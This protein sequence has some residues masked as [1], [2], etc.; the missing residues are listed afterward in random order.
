MTRDVQAALHW[1]LKSEGSTRPLALMRIFLVANLWARWGDERVLFRDLN[2]EPMLASTIFF[3]STTAAFF[4]MF[5]RVS[6]AVVALVINY[7]VYVVGHVYGHEPYTHH[8]TTLLANA[9]FLLALAPCGRSLS[10]DRWIELNRAEKQGRA[11]V[12][13]QANL[14]AQ[15]LIALQVA[16]IYFWGALDKLNPA[17]LSGARM[18]HYLMYYYTGPTDLAQIMSGL[19]VLM[20]ILAVLTVTLEFALAFGLLMSEY[21]KW[22]LVPG[23][24]LHGIFYMSLSVFTYTTTMWTLYLAVIEPDEFERVFARLLGKTPSSA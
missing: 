19:K 6:M 9:C 12:H 17:F 4:G 15:R 16:S 5:T 1:L 24:I 20:A 22:L 3:L 7:F 21:R 8:H 11:P 13:E 23:L 2:P 10:V 18:S 14:W